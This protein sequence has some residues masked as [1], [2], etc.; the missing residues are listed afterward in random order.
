[1]QR[2]TEDTHLHPLSC[3]AGT[4]ES[5]AW[6]HACPG[7]QLSQMANA[8]AKNPCGS[9]FPGAGESTEYGWLDGPCRRCQSLC[10]PAVKQR[11]FTSSGNAECGLKERTG[12]T[13]KTSPLGMSTWDTD[14]GLNIDILGVATECHFSRPRLKVNS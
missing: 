10:T 8:S 4:R 3:G 12:N 5:R 9:H 1:M 13:P 6:S 14:S 11:L 7:D 2:E